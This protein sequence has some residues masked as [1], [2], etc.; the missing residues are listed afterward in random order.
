M[1]TLLGSLAS[2]RS[3]KSSRRASPILCLLDN[4]YRT[5]GQVNSHWWLATRS[6]WVQFQPLYSPA[7]LSPWPSYYRHQRWGH[8][9]LYFGGSGRVPSR[10]DNVVRLLTIFSNRLLS[11]GIPHLLV[12]F[13]LLIRLTALL[14]MGS[15]SSTTMCQYWDHRLICWGV[16]WLFYWHVPIVTHCCATYSNDPYWTVYNPWGIC[17]GTPPS[18]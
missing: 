16:Y 12:H 17:V 4:L 2:H 11:P 6:H 15:Y 1:H 3:S 8:H 14:K 7:C 5:Q 10:S 18:L 9:E 13:I